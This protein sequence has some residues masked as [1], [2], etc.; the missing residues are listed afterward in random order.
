MMAARSYAGTAARERRRAA[1]HIVATIALIA[2]FLI[3]ATISGRSYETG[4]FKYNAQFAHYVDEDQYAR[5]ADAL[6]H[7]QLQ[8]DL[9]VADALSELENPYS[10]SSRH[11]ASQNG[12]NPIFWDHAYYEGHYYCY[13]GVVPAVV[14]YAPYQLITGTW[15]NT[16]DAVMLIGSLA[17]AAMSLLLYGVVRQYFPTCSVPAS[18]IA[19]LF[20][21]GGSNFAYLGFVSRFYSVPIL[22]SLL[23]TSLGLWLWIKAKHAPETTAGDGKPAGGALSAPLLFSGSLC[24]MLNLG[25]RPQFILACLLAFPLFWREI[26]VERR[27]FSRAS[28]KETIA[29]TAPIVIVAAPLLWYNGARFGSIFDFGS[30]YN[31]TGFDMTT[32]H[33]SWRL[34]PYLLYDYLFQPINLSRSFPFVEAVETK[35]PTGWAPREPM[36]GGYFWLVPYTISV[37]FVVKV[38]SELKQRALWGVS[39]LMIALAAIVLVVD[40]RTAGVTQRYMGDFGWYL[41]FVSAI[42]FLTY[43]T[44][45]PKPKETDVRLGSSMRYAVKQPKK[46]A[47]YVISALLLCITFAIGSLSILSPDRYDSIKAVSPDRYEAI[48][49]LFGDDEG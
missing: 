22:S 15:L 14:F 10:F 7:G 23:F 31:L 12:A 43:V 29:A 41:S 27:L 47:A 35:L 39:V 6:L 5:L 16:V 13:F 42:M 8:L 38:R 1:A 18:L 25:C 49:S 2:L 33:Q 34:T 21:F 11:E 46:A 26:A 30:S 17:V 19:L 45:K 40:T 24:M 36:F 20:V 28:V 4:E 37:F 3:S 48:T 9:P 32:Y 44:R